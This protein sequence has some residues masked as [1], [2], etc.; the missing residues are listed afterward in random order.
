MAF[1]KWNLKTICFRMD[2]HIPW[3]RKLRIKE[4]DS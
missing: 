4:R 2:A 3:R 1:R